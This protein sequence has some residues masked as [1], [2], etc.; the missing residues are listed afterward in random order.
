MIVFSNTTPLIALSSINQLE[1]LKKLFGEIYLVKE[2]VM[3]VLKIK[4]ITTRNRTK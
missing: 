4:K 1:L 2:V 3:D